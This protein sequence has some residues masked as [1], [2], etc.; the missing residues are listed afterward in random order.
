MRVLAVLCL[1]G[2]L[3]MGGGGLALGIHSSDVSANNS[4]ALH[5]LLLDGKTASAISARKTA[6]E[7]GLLNREVRLLKAQQ[8]FFH[9]QSV[10]GTKVLNVTVQG[11]ETHLDS[12][13]RSAIDQAA[14]RF[15]QE[16]GKP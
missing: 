1:L 6:R 12:T 3:I 9:R 7:V 14:A 13:I 8:L 4:V 10:N 15:A 5:N 2:A 16:L 11:I